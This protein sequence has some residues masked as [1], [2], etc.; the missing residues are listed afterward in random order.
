LKSNFGNRISP[1]ANHLGK[2]NILLVIQ[3]AKTQHTTMTCKTHIESHGV[4]TCKTQF[5]VYS[6]SYT[7]KN[8]SI[9]D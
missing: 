9:R 3:M 6:T 4:M 8:I 7:K 1:K 2:F 5:L